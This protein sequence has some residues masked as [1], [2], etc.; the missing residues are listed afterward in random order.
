MLFLLSPARAAG[1]Q[2][3]LLM[4]VGATFPLALEVQRRAW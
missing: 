2:M 4:R 3:Q 1:V